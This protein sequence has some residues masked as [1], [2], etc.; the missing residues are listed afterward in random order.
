MSQSQSASSLQRSDTGQPVASEDDTAC[1]H[2]AETGPTLVTSS[3]PA[4]VSQLVSPVTRK[5]NDVKED[6]GGYELDFW[7]DD[8]DVFQDHS[9]GKCRSSSSTFGSNGRSFPPLKKSKTS[10]PLASTRATLTDYRSSREAGDDDLSPQT[11]PI[12]EPAD[13]ETILPALDAS[14]QRYSPPSRP[15]GMPP[16]IRSRTLDELK[17]TIPPKLSRTATSSV[18]IL[19]RSSQS[20]IE[21]LNLGSSASSRT[22]VLGRTMGVITSQPNSRQ[23]SPALA[24]VNTKG[25]EATPPQGQRDQGPDRFH[26]GQRYPSPCLSDLMASSEDDPPRQ[27]MQDLLNEYDEDMDADYEPAADTTIDESYHRHYSSE[28]EDDDSY[29]AID[30]GNIAAALTYTD[31]ED[32]GDDHAFGDSLYVD[33]DPLSVDRLTE[34]EEECIMGE[35][36]EYGLNYVVRKYILS[37]VH[38]A[39]KMLLMTSAQPITLPADWTEGEIIALFKER[40]QYLMARGRRRLPHIHS[41]KHVADLLQNSKNIMIV[42]GAG[43]SVSCGIPD[44][45][46]PNGIYSRLSEFKLQEPQQMFD[47]D[48]FCDRPEIFYSF[49]REIFPSNFVPSPSHNFIKLVE[50]QG[51]LIR[52]YT[53]NIDT[54]EQK[55]GITKV[56]QCHGSFA[57]ASCIRCQHSVPGDDIKE[58]IFKQEVAYCKLCIDNPVLPAGNGDGISAQGAKRPL[59][60]PDIVF[61]NERLPTL[62]EEYLEEDRTKVDLLIVIGSSL[63]VAPVGDIMHQLPRH[64]PQILINRTPIIHSEFDV[65]LLGN[66]D[67]IVAELCRMVGWELKHEK[68]PGGTS[69]VPDLASYSNED[70]RGKGGRAPWTLV[71]PNT[72]LFEGAILQDIEYESR[73]SQSKG[74]D[75]DESQHF[76]QIDVRIVDDQD[77]DDD[78]DDESPPTR[79]V[80]ESR[81]CYKASRTLPLSGGKDG[82][83][84]NVTF[85]E[86]SEGSSSGDSVASAR[87]DGATT[88]KAAESEIVGMT[89]GT[90]GCPPSRSA[91]RELSE[92]AHGSQQ[93]PSLVSRTDDSPRVSLDLEEPSHAEPRP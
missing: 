18:D 40:L 75:D 46:S 22:P 63:K 11:S 51:K 6:D 4:S 8:L 9:E 16:L 76:S 71:E 47:L 65:Q 78:A 57:T 48:F 44:F 59:M 55:A 50:E 82:G 90:L 84:D 56:L 21:K 36:R 79:M 88:V 30:V 89:L 5:R 72:Y 3:L 19:A 66:C 24:A 13:L 73:Q 33:R 29:S 49:A 70:G 83:K 43:V 20:A 64:V 41:L 81:F 74:G 58:A 2:A 67:V 7:T 39:K 68:L 25:R 77:M 32:S 10:P 35:A 17:P 42:T 34:D 62:F 93:A 14:R 37:R 61:F 86:P 12:L 91:P 26:S 38:S 15:P 52:N 45:R 54:L 1:K 28:S 92:E 27:R 53:Q 87:R 23:A 85:S 80:S 31:C 60:K 69:K